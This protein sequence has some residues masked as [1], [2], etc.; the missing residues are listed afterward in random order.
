MVRPKPKNSLSNAEQKRS[1]REKNSDTEKE[2]DRIYKAKT[3]SKLIL[4]EKKH[5]K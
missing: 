1:W 4:E 3:H 2:A 5:E